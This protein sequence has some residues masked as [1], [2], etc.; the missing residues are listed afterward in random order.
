MTGQNQPPDAP[1]RARTR[2]R[3]FCFATFRFADTPR[4]ELVYMTAS[5]AQQQRRWLRIGMP[6]SVSARLLDLDDGPV[7]NS[8][9]GLTTQNRYEKFVQNL[10]S[11]RAVAATPVRTAAQRP[12]YQR[13]M[14]SR[15]DTYGGTFADWPDPGGAE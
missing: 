10:H 8:N 2:K 11:G 1:P 9:V 7:A 6:G 15:H 14:E 4:F 13:E 3:A 5:A 12:Q